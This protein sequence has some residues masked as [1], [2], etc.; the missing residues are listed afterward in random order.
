[1]TASDDKSIKIFSISSNMTLE[2]LKSHKGAVTSISFNSST[3]TLVSGSRDK[4]VI[5]WKTKAKIVK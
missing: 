2:V 1:M 3:N 5:I 4:S